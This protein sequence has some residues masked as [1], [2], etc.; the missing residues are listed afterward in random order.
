MKQ[1]F[2]IPYKPDSV[3]GHWKIARGGKRKILSDEGRGFRDKVQ[4]FLKS[5]GYETFKGRLKVKV[6]LFFADNRIR[7]I[8]NYFKSIFDC[9]KGFLF[10]DD[11]QIFELEAT[12]HIGAGKNYFIIEVEELQE[13]V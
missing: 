2:E 6:N 9:L 3:N 1:K 13:W 11:D 12:K 5:K 4:W 10:I 7:D 8:D